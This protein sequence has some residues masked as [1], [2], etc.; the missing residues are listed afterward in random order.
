MREMIFLGRDNTLDWQLQ[1][2]GSAVDL[3]SVTRMTAELSG[4]NGSA[5][6]DSDDD[7]NG[8]GN[9]FYWTGGVPESDEANLFL[10]LG[11]PLETAGLTSGYYNLRLTIYDPDHADGLVWL[12]SEPVQVD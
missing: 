2:D 3:A 12:S 9:P 1:A 7:G 4:T 10:S 6:V 11:G 8:Q 5:T